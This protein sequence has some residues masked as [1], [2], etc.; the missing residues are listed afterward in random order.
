MLQSSNSNSKSNSFVARRKNFSIIS[1]GL[2]DDNNND[3]IDNNNNNSNNTTTTTTTTT[4]NNNNN[5][6]GAAGH[7]PMLRESL[8]LYF[9]GAPYRPDDATHSGDVKTWLE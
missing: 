4:T 2:G 3:H 7:R 8:S 5:M 6:R 1:N 9:W